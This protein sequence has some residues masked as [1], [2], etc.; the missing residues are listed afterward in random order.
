MKLSP[1][2]TLTNLRQ[3]HPQTVDKHQFPTLINV[4]AAPWDE[5]AHCFAVAHWRS[6]DDPVQHAPA[7]AVQH[8]AEIMRPT[9]EAARLC[10]YAMA[11]FQI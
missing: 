3:I 9:N 1:N 4:S 5:V 2:G 6:Q 10:Q 7:I 11:A 8:R